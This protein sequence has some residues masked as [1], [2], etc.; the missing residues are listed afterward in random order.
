[1]R[2]AVR[3]VVCSAS[4]M[5]VAVWWAA[6]CQVKKEP[7]SDKLYGDVHTGDTSHISVPTVQ[8]GSSA[9]GRVRVTNTEDKPVKVRS[10]H[11]RESTAG[12]MS[13]RSRGSARPS[14]FSA[15]LGTCAGRTLKPG[16]SCAIEIV[17]KPTVAGVSTVL[18]V[19][20]TDP[21]SATIRVELVVHASK[22]GGTTEEPPSEP[23]RP[24]YESRK[25]SAEETNSSTTPAPE[26]NSSP[27]ASPESSLG[28]P[29]SSPGSPQSSPGSPESSPASPE[30][31]PGSP[32]SS[33]ESPHAPPGATEPGDSGSAS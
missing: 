13:Y 1:M 14:Q 6:G 26:S 2:G 23:G 21:P 28:S 19:I 7:G 33:P 10:V 11:T 32:E 20:E 15:D 18:L 17:S 3:R 24:T 16:E 25:P 9:V 30:S 4:V 31:S 27:A 29:D 22:S 5:A 12:P 8:V